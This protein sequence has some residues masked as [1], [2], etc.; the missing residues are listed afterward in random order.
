[1]KKARLR[2]LTLFGYE[3]FNSI[4]TVE[5]KKARLR[6]L[7]PLGANITLVTINVEMKK[8]RLRALTR[9]CSSKVFKVYT[10]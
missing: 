9:T 3:F 2:A 6:A 10:R 8:A 1:M 5:M 4:I 7:T